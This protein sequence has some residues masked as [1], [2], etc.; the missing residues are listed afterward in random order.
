MSLL[1]EFESVTEPLRLEELFPVA[2]PAELE[3]GCGDGGFLLEWA[4]RHPKKNFIGVERLLGR[5]R[6][7]DKKGRRAELTNL[8]LLRFEAQY[9]LQYL[10]PDHAFD[11]VHIYFPDPWPKD[12]HRRH[13]LI[14]EHFPEL[15]RRILLP[16]GIVHLRTDDPAYF[17][18]M[19]ESFL[20]AK[21]F[22]VTGTPVEL[23]NVTTE[24]ERQWNEE[25]KPT[26]R[27]SYRL[28]K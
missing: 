25:G 6:K 14:D 15:A 5:I 4:T 3:I 21:Y 13:R 9:L 16:N 22:S 20:P 11:A 23:A 18:Q 10:L 17:E 8:H 28:E 19:Q 1:H 2:Y 27:V 12:K 24:F 7:L 26:L